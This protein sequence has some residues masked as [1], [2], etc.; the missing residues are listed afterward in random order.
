[1]NTLS[2]ALQPLAPL[3]CTLITPHNRAVSL[4]AAGY[5][6]RPGR[7][8][9]LRVVLPCPESDLVEVRL[10]T[11]LDFIKAEP[12]WEEAAEDGKAVRVLPFLVPR[13]SF[14]DWKHFVRLCSASFSVVYSFRGRGQRHAVEHQCPIV[15]LPWVG[16]M[17]ISAAIGVLFLLGQSIF[18]QVMDKGVPSLQD[19]LWQLWDR[20]TDVRVL[21]LSAGVAVATFLIL[22]GYL[23]GQVYHRARELRQEFRRAYRWGG[24]DSARSETAHQT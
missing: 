13:D 7:A 10:L 6:L 17:L 3:S 19:W 18:V 1:M 9:R 21:A 20:I 4:G 12:A 2:P 23:Y 16:P 11:P 8:Y 5:I 22:F 14:L 24:G 15:V